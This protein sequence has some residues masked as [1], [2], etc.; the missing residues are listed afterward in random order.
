[1]L[2]CYSKLTRRSYWYHF[3]EK[4]EIENTELKKN[5]HNNCETLTSDEAKNEEAGVNEE[6]SFCHL[7]SENDDDEHHFDETE[8]QE[9]KFEPYD[10]ELEDGEDCDDDARD[11]QGGASEP[12][13]WSEAGDWFKVTEENRVTL[14]LELCEAYFLS[15]ALGKGQSSRASQEGVIMV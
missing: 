2:E 3:K 10:E 4:E 5:S 15:Y 9:S 7:K 13:N 8:R 14:H 1:M 12:R 6:D 11:E